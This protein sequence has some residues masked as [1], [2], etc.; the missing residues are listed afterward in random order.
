MLLGSVYNVGMDLT[1]LED[2]C[3]QRVYHYLEK[4]ANHKN[5]DLYLYSSRDKITSPVEF[6]RVILR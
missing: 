5:L 3:Y 1:I 2:R 4:F 6:I